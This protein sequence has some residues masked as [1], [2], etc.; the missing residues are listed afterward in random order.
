L[1]KAKTAFKS[2][3]TANESYII[4]EIDLPGLPEDVDPHAYVH[5]DGWVVAYYSKY[6]PASK[7][8][9][10][11]GYGGGKIT[12]TTLA[13]AMH[14]ICIAIEFPYTTIKDD[15]EYYDFEYPNANRMMLITDMTSEKF[16]SFNLTI[17]LS[18]EYLLYEGA[19]SH[20]LFYSRYDTSTIKIDGG[21]VSE[22]AC[23]DT[24]FG[25]GE[26]TSEQLE[27]EVPHEISIMQVY[28]RK[29]A[30]VAVVLIYRTS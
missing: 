25:Y 12:T 10:W 21:T 23:S 18:L 27:V 19:W 5:K 6:A 15:I 7:I 29:T 24:C 8:M 26:F 28:G 17:P 20:Y 16:D 11:E 22:I 9:E 13:D 2:I 14:E 4:G 30:G 1:E 3:E